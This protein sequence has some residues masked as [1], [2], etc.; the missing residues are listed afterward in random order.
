MNIC[1][2]V[3]ETREQ[4]AP[5]VAQRLLDLPGVG[6]HASEGGKL[7]VTVEDTAAT[8]AADTLGLLGQV[9]GVL[10]TSLI[11][12]YGGDEPLEDGDREHQSA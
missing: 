10:N 6:L 8:M 12:H 9:D 5:M 3:V 7:V 11:Y 4:D 1:G 2:C